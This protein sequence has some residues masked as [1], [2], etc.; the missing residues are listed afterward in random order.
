LQSLKSHLEGAGGG[1]PDPRAAADAP[2]RAFG[3]G[4]P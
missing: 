3:R 1:D 4:V 2:N